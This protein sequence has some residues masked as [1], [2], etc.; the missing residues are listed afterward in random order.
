[1]EIKPFKIK[2]TPEQSKIVQEVL[3]A[4]G[5]KWSGDLAHVIHTDRKYLIVDG[6]ISTIGWCMREMYDSETGLPELTFEQFQ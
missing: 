3:F 4:N 6:R 1:M 5:V 2:V